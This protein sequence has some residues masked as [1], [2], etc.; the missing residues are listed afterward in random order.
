MGMDPRTV[1]PEAIQALRTMATQAEELAGF[2]Q[3]AIQGL[4][5]AF[6]SNKSG[7]GAHVA[8]ISNL[9]QDVQSVGEEGTKPVKK[10]VFKL[11]N[12]ADLRQK[13]LDEDGYGRKHK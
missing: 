11:D 5:E 7:L 13:H 3:R 10:L 2:I 9:I 8:S 4:E 12:A 1:T 6:E